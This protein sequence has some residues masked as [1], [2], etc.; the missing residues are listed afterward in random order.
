MAQGKKKKGDKASEKAFILKHTS[1]AERAAI[2]KRSKNTP[3]TRAAERNADRT[4]SRKAASRALNGPAA[5][6]H[7]GQLSRA[8]RNAKKKGK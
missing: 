7:A 2:S 1:A 4:G 8:K 5:A 6:A 3:G